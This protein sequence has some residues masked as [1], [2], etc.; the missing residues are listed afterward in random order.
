MD[1]EGLQGLIVIER[2]IAFIRTLSTSEIESLTLGFS[3]FKLVSKIEDLGMVIENGDN[4]GIKSRRATQKPYDEGRSI[5]PKGK[6]NAKKSKR[7]NKKEKCDTQQIKEI[8]EEEVNEFD[9]YIRELSRFKTIEEATE[10][11]VNNKLTVTKL[12]ILAK[13]LSL[14]IKSKVKKSDIIEIIVDGIVGSR[15]RLESLRKY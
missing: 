5:A 14:Y 9:I 2:A 13:K 12:K 15:I 7:E 3:D 11:L 10:Y 4:K 8:V 6:G 1:K